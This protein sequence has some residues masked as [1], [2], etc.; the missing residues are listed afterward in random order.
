MP[1]SNRIEA[2]I[3][4]AI[5][6][7]QG[8]AGLAPAQLSSALH[9]AVTP[10]GARI[11]P[12]IL[13]SVAHACGD[14]MPLVSESAA[15]ALELIHCASLV[16]DDLPSFDDADVRRGK[17]T[18][19]KAY[20]EPLAVLTGDSLIVLA[21]EILANA[22][23]KDPARALA[24][25][26][27]LAQR[28]GSPNGICAGQA[29]ESETKVNLS[30]YHRAKTGALF[31]AATQMGAIAA[32]QD[33]EPWEELGARIGEA[34]QVADDLRD[35]LYDADTLGKPAGQDD[36]HGRPNA[37]SEFGVQGAIRR[38]KDILAG[39]I[40][41]IPSCKGEADLAQLVRHTAER[42]TPVH[43]AIP[44]E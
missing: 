23:V 11:R 16:H 42:M 19:H 25:V 41:S 17:P 18:V 24:L 28:T 39:A 40:S 1:H 6:L 20:S 10:G 14:D 30:A 35:A 2:A 15:A 13:M 29:W 9:Y 22:G 44:A 4:R 26:Q 7:G 5:A 33:A 3:G 21:F 36:L 38:L 37:V 31:I 34:F 12:T 32:G 8:K 27:A 43:P